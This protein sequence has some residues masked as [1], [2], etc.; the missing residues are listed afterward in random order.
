MSIGY[1]IFYAVAWL[2]S[3]LPFWLLY[4]VA[5]FVFFMLYH[6]IGYR[7]EVTRQNLR[8]SFPEKDEKWVKDTSKKFYHNLADI[9]LEDIKVLT[10]PQNV[11]ECLQFLL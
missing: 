2:I 1:Y 3:L 8:N 11:L 7:K 6:V 5:D 9:I 4:G 10:I